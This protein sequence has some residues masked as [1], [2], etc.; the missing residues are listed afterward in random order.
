LEFERFGRKQPQGTI[1]EMENRYR[2]PALDKGLDIIELLA[3]EPGG[4]TRAEIIKAM[5]RSQSEI[6]RMLERLVARDY[7]TRMEGDRHFL[8]MKMFVLA[9][10]YPPVNRLLSSAKP[11]MA[12]FSK[13]VYQSC[14][15]GYYDRGAIT[16]IAQQDSPGEW[17][18]NLRL[19]A[20]IDLLTTGSGM[21]H[22]AFQSEETLKAI[23][24]ES[25][26]ALDD[27]ILR[28][29]RAVKQQGY[30]M[31]PSRQARGMVD[32]SAPVMGPNEQALAVV[33]CPFIERL[34]G[35]ST[36]NIDIALTNLREL[37]NQLS[38]S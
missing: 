26:L 19:G 13:A 3:T 11:L 8:S 36:I 14:H 16:V 9:T 10:H 12:A 22:L 38:L 33:T 5:G 2:A 1:I 7:V 37:A 32:I 30:W 17:G 20:H 23:V 31:A 28:K 6:Y 24:D 15:L 27:A 35:P 4:L 29:L 25:G 21:T 34:E 18:L